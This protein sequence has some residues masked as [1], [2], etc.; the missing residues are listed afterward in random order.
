MIDKLRL[1]HFKAFRDSAELDLGGKNILVFGE[2]GAGKSSLYQALKI[3]FHRQ[4]IFNREIDPTVKDPN[5]RRNAENDVL[6]KFNYQ[7]TPLTNFTLEIDGTD[8]KTYGTAGLDVS[9]ISRDDLRMEDEI[10]VI[11]VLENSYVGITDAA[12]FVVSKKETI[13]TLLNSFLKEYFYEE[14]LTVA[15]TFNNPRWLLTI[16]DADRDSGGRNEELAL[17]FNEAK[18]HIIK[19]LLLLTA[20]QYNG[21]RERGDELVLVLDDVFTSMDS[22]NRTLFIELLKEYF[23]DY[24]KIIMTHSISFF[25]L[26]VHA[27]TIAYQQKDDWKLY[28]IVEHEANSE[29]ETRES[30]DYACIINRDYKRHAP[31]GTIGNRIRK[32][33]EFLVGEVSKL[34]YTGG[35]A[36]CSKLIEAINT[37]KKLYYEYDGT[38]TNTVYDLVD[39]LTAI[40]DADGGSPLKLRLQPVID[41]YVSNTEVEKLRDTIR[42][43]SVYQKVSMHPLSHATGALPLST[44]KEVERSITLLMTLEKQ[45]GTL[46]N[47]DLYSM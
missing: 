16:S 22:A 24:Q 30:Q 39:E 3:I 4:T 19:L 10:N 45:I 42:D 46:I 27:F 7:A 41:R 25:N 14:N 20:V 44:T 18:L 40:V 13:E 37:S 34:V 9:M 21:A 43:L 12:A 15:L 28:Q 17:Y 11:D 8:Y 38:K 23:G 47:K 36:E 35:L 29:I 1:E 32:R 5:D 26:A 2:N 31:L 6:A 33:F